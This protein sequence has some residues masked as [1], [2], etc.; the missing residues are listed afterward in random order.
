MLIDLLHIHRVT[1]VASQGKHPVPGCVTPDAWVTNY[2]LQFRQDLT[3]WRNYTEDGAV[4]VSI[5]DD[6]VYI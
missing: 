4:K 6:N 5:I 3:N 1:D 2:S